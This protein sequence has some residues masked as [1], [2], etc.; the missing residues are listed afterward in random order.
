MGI[1]VLRDVGEVGLVEAAVN[2]VDK[3]ECPPDL[4][5]VNANDPSVTQRTRQTTVIIHNG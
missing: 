4:L 2:D 3:C 5:Q 1:V